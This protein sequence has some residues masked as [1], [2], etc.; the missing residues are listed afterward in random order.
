MSKVIIGIVAKHKEDRQTKIDSLIHDE[1]KQAIF[2]NDGI[3]IGIL[4]PNENIIYT[5]NDWKDYEDK[6]RK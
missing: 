3:A 6:I 4:S 1:V 2:D 5:G